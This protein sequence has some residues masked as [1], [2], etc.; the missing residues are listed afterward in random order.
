MTTRLTDCLIKLDRALVHLNA[1]DEAIE[2]WK[3]RTTERISGSYDANTAQYIYRSH[4]RPVPKREWSAIIGDM[5]TN[6]R[7]ALDYLAWQLT[8]CY[9][10]GG[11][12]TRTG[13]SD[14][15]HS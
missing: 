7:A 14:L 12:T 3:E 10:P 13:I 5:L 11:G 6:C 2:Q 9:T 4:S 15:S 1:L 8:D